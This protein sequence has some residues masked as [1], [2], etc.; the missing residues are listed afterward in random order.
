MTEDQKE[1]FAQEKQRLLQ[2]NSLILAT[3]NA[4]GQPLASSTPF[5]TKGEDFYIFISNKLSP[6]TQNLLTCATANILLVEDESL[7]RNNFAR[8]RMNLNV[9]AQT[10][11]RDDEVY[12]EVIDLMQ[13]KHGATVELLKG[14]ADFIMFK[15]V[16]AESRLVLGFGQAFAFEAGK[17][18]EA[19][20]ITE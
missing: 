14:M 13:A 6:H 17:D 2:N 16:P 15:L 7:C 10:V 8:A 5:V 18:N 19:T 1:K 11:S 9:E 12:L 20:H 3:V 4:E